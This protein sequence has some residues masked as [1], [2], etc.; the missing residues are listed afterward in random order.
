[1]AAST[2]QKS[3]TWHVLVTQLP[4]EANS[5]MRI[6][7]ML[8]AMGCGILRDSVFLLPDTPT[9]R[10]SLSKLGEH[11][12]VNGGTHYLLN[13]QS[14]EAQSAAFS[15]LFNRDNL[16]VELIKTLESLRG[17]FGVTDPT[18]I[19]RTVIKLAREFETISSLD[20]FPSAARE[21]AEKSLQ[22]AQSDVRKLLFPQTADSSTTQR[23]TA[24]ARYFRRIWV[25]Y[26]P[27]WAD[28]LASAWLIRRFIDAEST[29]LWGER[30]HPV[31]EMAVSFG[32]EGAQFCNTATQVTYEVLLDAFN[33]KDP[34][35]KRIAGIIHALDIGGSQVPEAAGVESLL[36]GAQRRAPDEKSLLAETEKTFDLLYDAYFEQPARQA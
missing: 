3:Q 29:V 34:A 35:L 11:I 36:Q 30:G 32:F 5:R 14:D 9:V 13:V 17:G 10:P 24:R 21:R 33:M 6:L 22:A 12:S 28:R 23:I 20:F 7:R 4:D 18:S 16:Y 2:P 25:T 26:K 31:P 15:R 1:M 19:S 8:E 27:L